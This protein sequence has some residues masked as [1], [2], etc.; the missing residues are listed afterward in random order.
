VLVPASWQLFRILDL[1]QVGF[2][3]LIL[4]VR[5]TAKAEI[6]YRCAAP[7]VKEALDMNLKFVLHSNHPHLIADLELEFDGHFFAA[8]RFFGT[9]VTTTRTG[10]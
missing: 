10:T 1:F 7:G 4:L 8:F 6:F 3:E 5:I 2:G 9:S